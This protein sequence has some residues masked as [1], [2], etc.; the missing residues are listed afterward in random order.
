M[1]VLGDRGFKEVIKDEVI[2][3]EPPVQQGWSP[4]KERQTHRGKN[5]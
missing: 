3:M 2:R 1:M 5:I 4:Y